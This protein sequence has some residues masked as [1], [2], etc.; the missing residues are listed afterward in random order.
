MRKLKWIVMGLVAVLVAVVVAGYVVLSTMDFE[1]LRETI[2]AEAS[3]ATGRDLVLA[4]PIDVKVSLRPAVAIDQ[5]TFAN[6]EWGSRP[7]MV[8]LE[9][10][11]V[12]VALLP[13][14]S[15][16]L[17]VKRLVLIGP[18]ILLETDAE[19]RV[20]WE[21]A[22][23]AEEAE[24][25]EEPAEDEAAELIPSFD[26]II[27]R[28]GRLTYRDGQT[29]EEIKLALDKVIASSKGPSHPLDIEFEGVYNG[30]AVKLAGT[31]GSFDQLTDGPFPL[32]I[33]ASAGGADVTL[34]GQIAEAMT[35]KGADVKVTARGEKLEG[36]GG[37]AGTELP[38][39]GAFD[40]AT[41]VTWDGA[42]LGLSELNVTAAD[43]GITAQ[44]GIANALEQQGVD[45]TVTA[46]GE[47]LA[48]LGAVADAELPP[49]GPYDVST[50]V[51]MDGQ[52]VTISDL[53]AKVGGSDLAG[54]ATVNLG[55]PM[56]VSA[57]L[58]SQVLDLADFTEEGAEEPAAAAGEESPYVFTED[59]LPLEALQGTNA[60]VKLTAGTLKLQDK[61]A[62][63]NLDLTLSLAGG[64][65]QVAPLVA[66]FSG[67]SLEA[68]VDLDG[69]KATPTL[70]ALVK[71]AGIDYGQLLKD[72]EIDETVQG[73][74][75]LDIDLKGAGGS[76]RA[77]AAG[78]NGKTEIV[79][80]EGVVSNRLMKIVGVGLGDIM[81]P[82]FGGE[83]NTKLHCIV[84]RFDVENGLATSRAM[85]FDSEAF[86]VTGAGTVD[87]TTE[88]LDLSMDTSTR[89]TSIA[90]LAVPFNSSL[91]AENVASGG[92]ENPCVAAVEA[93]ER[94]EVPAESEPSSPV[95]AV[96]E[97]PAKVL[98]GI[99]E[100]VTEGLKGLFGD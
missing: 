2:Q 59:P 64:R 7:E 30:E 11:E 37:L 86:T 25:A 69:G 60:D 43:L 77:I 14:L 26:Q 48:S 35:G 8:S 49:L 78:L 52:T 33:S 36:L 100:G 80:N 54:Q 45:L 44:G 15:G 58:S 75:D 82:L 39:V 79:S 46:R 28:D 91:I 97:E 65:L 9:R 51:Q 31:L 85:I 19:G 83:D 90:S 6:A 81:G 4:G 93:A 62:L 96:I 67:G 89:E 68:N 63:E 84:S 56:T 61:M 29:G 92:E 57:N 22:A 50:R 41:R 98:E 23:M 70:V 5:V 95:E 38:P 17:E 3:A 72:M 42:V 94:G 55:E 88:K 87:L 10:F 24:E 32:K 20:N 40:V 13:L 71:G 16:N 99:G 47:S 34:D 27:I 53:V 1:D 74:L 21:L 18:D 76:M 73:T 12:E 66:G